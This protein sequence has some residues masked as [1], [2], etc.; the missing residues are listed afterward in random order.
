LSTYSGADSR[1]GFLYLTPSAH[2]YSYCNGRWHCGLQAIEQ[3]SVLCAL[4]ANQLL[5]K[6]KEDSL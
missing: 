6:I 4:A 1:T 3:A 2:R 5:S